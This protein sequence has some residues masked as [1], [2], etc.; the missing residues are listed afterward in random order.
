MPNNPTPGLARLDAVIAS[1]GFPVRPETLEEA[2]T[3]ALKTPPSRRFQE[4]ARRSVEGT[5]PSIGEEVTLVVTLRASPGRGG[6]LERAALEFVEAT[7]QLQGAL[8]STLYQ[9][10][11]DP[12]TLILIERFVDQEAF[13]RHMAADYF[14]HFQV[15]Q[16]P[17][18]AAPTEALFLK[19]VSE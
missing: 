19:P 11:S 12:L 2:W 9:S 13:N 18:L 17:L 5:A 6:E 1:A 3:L 7:R 4:R 15:V 14:R 8:G 16:A 10:S